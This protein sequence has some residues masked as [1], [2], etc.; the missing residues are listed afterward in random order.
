MEKT[1]C[2]SSPDPY[3]ELPA[4][5]D[6]EHESFRDD[7]ELFLRLAEVVGDPLAHG[8][9]GAAVADLADEQSWMR[10]LHGG[11]RRERRPDTIRRGVRVPREPERHQ[12]EYQHQQDVAVLQHAVSFVTAILRRAASAERAGMLVRQLQYGIGARLRG[13][14]SRDAQRSPGGAA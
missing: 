9:V 10:G 7:I 4:L 6:I 1:V 13:F 14:P 2:P 5:Y 3:A 12:R 8:L 11:S